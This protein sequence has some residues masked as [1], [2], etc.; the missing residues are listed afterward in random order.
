M[1]DSVIKDLNFNVT[2]PSLQERMSAL[3]VSA[4]SP[5]GY[6]DKCM[7]TY[8][9]DYKMC[10]ILVHVTGFGANF[11]EAVLKGL[12]VEMQVTVSTSTHAV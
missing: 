12:V 10:H 5:H 3:N 7:W 9:H 8:Q 1:K 6:I 4:I 2:Q 11:H